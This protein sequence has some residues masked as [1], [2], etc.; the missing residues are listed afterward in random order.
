MKSAGELQS[1][2]AIPVDNHPVFHTALALLASLIPFTK[3]L[4]LLL[5]LTLSAAL[6]VNAAT[7]NQERTVAPDTTTTTALTPAPPFG[8][9]KD[10]SGW[11][12]VAPDGHKFFSV[13][14][15]CL[16]QGTSREASDPENPSYAAWQNHSSSVAWADTN[17]MRLKAWG[18]ATAG[19]WADFDTLRQ[20]RE[21]SLW[22]TPVLHIGAAAG[23]PW[24]DMWDERNV[25]RMESVARERILPIRED[26]RLLGYYSDNELGWWNATLWKTTLE[27]PPSSGQCSGDTRTQN[28]RTHTRTQSLAMRRFAPALVNR[29]SGSKRRAKERSIAEDADHQRQ[30]TWP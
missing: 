3:H 2:R 16:H 30:G 23:A 13:G 14:V 28:S 29:L 8:T 25:R 1:I 22:F 9:V 24:W 19:G 4:G 26:P 12:M 7:A 17:L 6:T 15:C 21:Q 18:F 27:H 20:S 10:E 5:S 11:W